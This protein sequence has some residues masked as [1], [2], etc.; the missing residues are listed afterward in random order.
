MIYYYYTFHWIWSF[1]KALSVSGA[2]GYRSARTCFYCVLIPSQASAVSPRTLSLLLR[3]HINRIPHY[4]EQ[5]KL[6]F[7]F[8]ARY[9]QFH[10][11]F[12]SKAVLHCP[13]Y[14]SNSNADPRKIKWQWYH[15]LSSSY[16]FLTD[17]RGTSETQ[18]VQRTARF[19]NNIMIFMIIL[20]SESWMVSQY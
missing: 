7:L 8:L 1:T 4:D 20:I 3:S 17:I 12:D 6:N 15:R 19:G 13:F 9:E 5:M 18:Q 2:R 10:S 11:C 16:L 14:D